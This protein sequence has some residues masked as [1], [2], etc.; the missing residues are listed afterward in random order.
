[1]VV[2]AMV[3]AVEALAADLLVGVVPVGPT[4]LPSRWELPLEQAAQAWVRTTW[5]HAAQLGRTVHALRAHRSARKATG[6]LL[7]TVDPEEWLAP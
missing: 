7:M 1:M 4:A 6:E 5:E 2:A 3:V